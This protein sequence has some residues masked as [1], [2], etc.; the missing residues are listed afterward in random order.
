MVSCERYSRLLAFP[1]LRSVNHL[2]W[3][4]AVS[5]S[6]VVQCSI[7]TKEALV[8]STHLIR[9]DSTYFPPLCQMFGALLKSP[10]P[11]FLKSCMGYALQPI[12]E[13]L[14]VWLHCSHI[15]THCHY[16]MIKSEIVPNPGSTAFKQEVACCIWKLMWYLHLKN[17]IYLVKCNTFESNMCASYLTSWT[18]YI[19][20]QHT[21]YSFMCG[22][23]YN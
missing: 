18:K 8:F 16:I 9:F 17:N 15:K 12:W 2:N 20:L 7:G 11:F 5:S 1:F 13:H 10:F 19:I 4:H 3:N 22:S 14:P 21:D 23:L 6:I